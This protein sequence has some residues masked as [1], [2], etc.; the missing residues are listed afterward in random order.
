MGGV[1]SEVALGEGAIGVAAAQGCTVRLCDM[2]RGRRFAA[3]VLAT[4]GADA[5]RSIPLPGLADPQS[6]LAVPL[7]SMGKVRGVLFAED[8]RRFRFRQSEED[9]LVMIASQLA[10]SLR[11]AELEN[12]AAPPKMN[13]PATTQGPQF[14]VRYHNFDDSL[15]IDG[16][17]VIKGVPGRLLLHFL[18]AY[19]QTGRTDFTNRELRLDGTLRLP[20]LK[21]NLETRLILLRRRLAEKGSPVQLSRPGRGHIRLELSGTPKLEII[22]GVS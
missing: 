2:S 19:A 1:G 12:A 4:G 22:S 18:Q 21:D 5:A 13:P 15:F 6:Q 10:A 14:H 16:N 8:A 9:A 7:I 11:L 3:A 17:Y 20:D